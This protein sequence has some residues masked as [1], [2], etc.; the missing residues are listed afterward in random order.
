MQ[1]L[2]GFIPKVL[3]H[4]GRGT[5]W[6]GDIVLAFKLSAGYSEKLQGQN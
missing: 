1:D 6:V 5:R 4:P 2:R 3:T